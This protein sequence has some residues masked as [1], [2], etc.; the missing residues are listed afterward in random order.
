LTTGTLAA[1]AHY[2][3]GVALRRAGDK[4]A[5]A[6]ALRRAD[7]LLTPEE[8][9]G[10]AN[11]EADLLCRIHEQLAEL[12]DEAGDHAEA[13]CRAKQAL[14]MGPYVKRTGPWD[15]EMLRV[16]AHATRKLGSQRDVDD[17][18]DWILSE[19]GLNAA[20]WAG[21]PRAEAVQSVEFDSLR[22]PG[23]DA[24][25]AEVA[26]QE[27]VLEMLNLDAAMVAETVRGAASRPSGPGSDDPTK[28]PTDPRWQ[29]WRAVQV[30]QHVA[31]LVVSRGDGSSNHQDLTID[32]H[33]ARIP[34]LTLEDVEV[35]RVVLNRARTDD[36]F[37]QAGA[38]GGS[39]GSFLNY[40]LPGEDYYC[41]PLPLSER[42]DLL[43]RLRFVMGYEANQMD[44]WIAEGVRMLA[45]DLLHG[46]P[47]IRRCR[48]PRGVTAHLDWQLGEGEEPDV[49]G[50]YYT[51]SRTGK[52]TC[53]HPTCGTYHGQIGS[54]YK[55][56]GRAEQLAEREWKQVGSPG[57]FPELWN[58]AQHGREPRAAL[59][60][61]R[62]MLASATDTGG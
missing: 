2:W 23:P 40:G 25:W 3:L 24:P 39:D 26:A 32:P 12:A 30:L 6:K 5:A 9:R 48:M 19:Y 58:Q 4:A 11:G 51:R 29:R 38:E 60:H 22:T 15:W 41:G 52:E 55:L 42:V 31:G 56:S 13:R 50:R 43:L 45:G 28:L 10:L 8:E 16:I 61:F 34:G 44:L 18:L 33:T 17:T 14:E 1:L 46:D 27:R 57:S 59:A 62:E 35:L 21:H 7:V 37:V 36:V 53:G 20:A 54:R 49:C 47:V